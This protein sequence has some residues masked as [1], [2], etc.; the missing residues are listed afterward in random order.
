MIYNWTLHH[1]ELI[2]KSLEGWDI[3]SNPNIPSSNSTTN[4]LNLYVKVVANSNVEFIFKD[5]YAQE[6]KLDSLA[7]I[8]L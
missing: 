2:D 5:N 1:V 4:L 6:D 3:Y 7:F 8:C